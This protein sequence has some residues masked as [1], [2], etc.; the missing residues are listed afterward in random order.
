MESLELLKFDSSYEYVLVLM[1]SESVL[2]DVRNIKHILQE[3]VIIDADQKGLGRFTKYYSYISTVVTLI[4]QIE[5]FSLTGCGPWKGFKCPSFIR[6]ITHRKFRRLKSLKVIQEYPLYYL[7]MVKINWID[8]RPYG[9]I[10]LTYW[11]V[12]L[13]W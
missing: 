2:N 9:W 7:W 10:D 4:T 12:D 6:I 1:V 8:F 11:P 13:D 3:T 5:V